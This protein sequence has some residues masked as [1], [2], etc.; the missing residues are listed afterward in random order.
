MKAHVCMMFD[1][2]SRA[3]HLRIGIQLL[4]YQSSMQMLYTYKSA[5]QLMTYRMYIIYGI[6]NCSQHAH[7]ANTEMVSWT[8]THPIVGDKLFHLSVLGMIKVHISKCTQVWSHTMVVFNQSSESCCQQAFPRHLF[9][10]NTTRHTLPQMGNS[11]AY[12]TWR[13]HPTLCLEL[14]CLLAKSVSTV[15]LSPWVSVTSRSSKARPCQPELLHT[16]Q[17]IC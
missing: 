4:S 9:T 11:P 5:A 12:N 1:F 17:M 3:V 10:T 8:N 15:C 16:G 6:I 7:Q 14:N 2:Y 13:Y